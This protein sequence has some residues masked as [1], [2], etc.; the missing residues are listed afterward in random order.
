MY[1]EQLMKIKENK[2]AG[3]N[4]VCK[5]EILGMYVVLIILANI[6]KVHNLPLL[7]IPLSLCVFIFL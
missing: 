2:V 7:L 6:V 3:L 1:R 5:L 4:P